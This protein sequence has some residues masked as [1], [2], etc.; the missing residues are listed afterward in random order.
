MKN[1]KRPTNL[2]LRLLQVAG[3]SLT[4]MVVVMAAALATK[5]ADAQTYKVLYM[6]TGNANGGGPTYQLVRIG[7]DLYG[8][9]FGGVDGD[10]I[11]F[12]L[13][14]DGRET[15]LHRFSGD[16]GDGPAGLVNDAAGNLYGLTQTGGNV[17]CN[18]YSEP[19]GCGVIFE[20]TRSGE[21]SVLY[22]FPGDGGANPQGK[23][24]LDAKGNLYG[25]AAAGGQSTS[26][27]TEYQLYEQGC[28]TIFALARGAG[29]WNETVLYNFAGGTD[30]FAPNGSLVSFAGK[31]FGTAATNYSHP[32]QSELCGTVFELAPGKDGWT[33]KTLHSF[34]G[35]E[36][37][38]AEDGLVGDPEGNLYGTTLSG[39][40][41]GDGT[42]FKI[43]PQ[44]H[45]TTLYSFDG[46]DGAIHSRGWSATAVVISLAPPWRVA[47]PMQARCS[48]SI[49]RII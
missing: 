21:F 34:K 47:L 8:T 6:F 11:V 37:A 19:N 20:I 30:S 41:S 9:T 5:S 17:G 3:N 23:L 12:K 39:G 38:I 44:G 29:T 14:E 13:A 26:C 46:K 15:V 27:G 24:L 25:A 49:P 1:S 22:S 48:G 31:L 2:R 10:G 16:D 32:C 43:D 28:G 18:V 45:N 42:I 35:G 36:G 40:A 33:D 7:A 4:W